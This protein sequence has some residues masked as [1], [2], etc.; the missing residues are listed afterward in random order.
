MTKMIE[1]T[2]LSAMAS[3]MRINIFFNY[4]TIDSLKNLYT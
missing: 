3:F 2:T 1:K 4:T